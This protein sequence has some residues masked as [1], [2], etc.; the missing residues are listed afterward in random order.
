MPAA[1]PAIAD[2]IRIWLRDLGLLLCARRKELGI[3]A[4]V[5]AEAAGI[6]RMTLHRIE[7]GE[8][9]VTIGA[10]LSVVSALGLRWE[11]A[12]TAR[13]AEIQLPEKIR[14]KEFPQ[15]HRLSWQLKDTQELS[16]QEA[17]ELYER[18]WKYVD[19]K[20]MERRER[21]FLERLL[22]KFGKE[23]PLV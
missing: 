8:P 9:S 11:L 15:L 6:A 23:R 18:N 19:L 3:S 17:L 4:T 2:G 5:A 1:S 22:A 20:S 12:S 14:V 7:R 10:Y 21:Q 16:L 13:E